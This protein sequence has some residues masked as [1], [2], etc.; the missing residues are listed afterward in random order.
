MPFVSVTLVD[1]RGSAPQVKGAKALITGAGIEAGTIGGG[2]IEAAAIRHAQALLSSSKGTTCDFV[3]WNLQTEIGMT[4]GGEVKLFFE[5]Y[6]KPDWPI[7]VYGA[8]HVAQALL[9]ILLQLHC[10]VTWIDPRSSWLDK[11]DD[12]P[13]LQKV[14]CDDP[15]STV[16]H[17]PDNSFFVLISKGHSADLPVLAKILSTRD[18]PYVGVIGSNQ[19]ANVL[20][21]ELRQRNI[22]ETSIESFVCPIGLPLGNN[23]PAE[24]SISI[25]AQLIQRRDELG[26]L[27]HAVKRF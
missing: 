2:K 27:D 1:I 17:Q 9:P 10:R 22:G 20:R 4:C 15:E 21:R 23:T 25:L 13:K 19:K 3:T 18:A 12:H 6:G 8:G 7:A 16:A 26:I 11:I 5:V 24:I 14:C